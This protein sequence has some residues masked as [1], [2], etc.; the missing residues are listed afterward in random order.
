[1]EL[2]DKIYTFLKRRTNHYVS[3]VQGDKKLSKNT[4]PK[5]SFS[6][7]DIEALYGS[8]DNF[9][10][11][12]PQQGFTSDVKIHLKIING[13]GANASSNIR[14]TLTLNFTKKEDTPMQE[15]YPQ[16]TH[17][18][19]MAGNYPPIALGYAQVLQSELTRY[20]VVKERFDDLKKE[21]GKLE[22]ELKD[23]KSEIRDLKN[24]NFSLRLK[25][26]ILEEKH[27]VNLEKEILKKK[28]FFDSEVGSTFMNSLGNALPI[29]IEGVMSKSAKVPVGLA[30][31][32]LSQVKQA[33]IQFISST[34]ITDQQVEACFDFLNA[35]NN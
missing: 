34:E 1:M 10:K 21:N 2:T 19:P 17:T 20:E 24:E 33:F 5:Y 23:A 31:P 16:P 6:L 18:P 35:N 32:N 8:V 12:I 4:L 3:V 7:S 26:D 15:N 29:I 14:E 11:D 28:G 25:N 13:I 9:I 30:A 27:A 22:D